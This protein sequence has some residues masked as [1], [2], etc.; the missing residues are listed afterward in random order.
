MITSTDTVPIGSVVND[1]AE[2]SENERDNWKDPWDDT[3]SWNEGHTRDEKDGYW[4]GGT[5]DWD[6]EWHAI[7]WHS[8]AW[9]G[10]AWSGWNWNGKYADDDGDAENDMDSLN[11]VNEEELKR[12][13]KELDAQYKETSGTTETE[14]PACKLEIALR[15]AMDAGDIPSVGPL[16]QKMR[17]EVPAS[18]R[19]GSSAEKAAFRMKWAKAM[20]EKIEESRVKREEFID[21]E[22]ADGSYEPFD[23][24]VQRERSATI[25]KK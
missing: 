6:S 15:S 21:E 13:E 16:A 2:A 10:A 3:N 14:A 23:I 11:G 20:L 12:I 18:E 8:F 9:T 19:G 5:S 17:R 1:P 7:R 25:N 24:I 22:T 4:S